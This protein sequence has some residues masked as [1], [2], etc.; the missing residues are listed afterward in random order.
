MNGHN[1]SDEHNAGITPRPR[2]LFPVLSSDELTQKVL[3]KIA[4]LWEF[5]AAFFE[6]GTPQHKEF[7]AEVSEADRKMLRSLTLMR[8]A[9][10]ADD[11]IAKRNLAD[12]TRLLVPE[13]PGNT[14]EYFRVN[15]AKKIARR[16]YPALL[17]EMVKRA[18][19]S[20]S[21][22]FVP[23]ILCPNMTV[24]AFAFAAYRGISVCLNCQKLFAADSPRPDSSNSEKYCTAA[25]GQRYRQKVYRINSKRKGNKR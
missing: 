9:S 22:K 24:A 18:R 21:G 5:T 17:K 13:Y 23:E 6:L 10:S 25:C 4:H 19:L 8:C 20:I 7:E 16:L 2:I 11:P 3:G 15:D 14:G 12:V 1:E